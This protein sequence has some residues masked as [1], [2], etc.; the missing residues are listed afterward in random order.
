MYRSIFR[1]LDLL[2]SSVRQCVT[3]VILTQVHMKLAYPER[4]PACDH[5]WPIQRLLQVKA[6]PR[7]LRDLPTVSRLAACR[8]RPRQLA[9]SPAARHRAPGPQGFLLHQMGSHIF[10]AAVRWLCRLGGKKGKR[11]FPCSFSLIAA[12]PAARTPATLQQRRGEQAGI[13]LI[14]MRGVKT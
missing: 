12:R 7:V 2:L 8:R 14:S 11:R 1:I 9:N 10:F 5:L 6:L 13:G 3:F 4:K